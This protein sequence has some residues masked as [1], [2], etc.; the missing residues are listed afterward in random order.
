MQQTSA[1]SVYRVSLSWLFVTLTVLVLATNIRAQS[2][3]GQVLQSPPSNQQKSVQKPSPLEPY[4]P[5]EPS[6]GLTP[7]VQ[8]RGGIDPGRASHLSK[9]ETEY[10]AG[11]HAAAVP[12]LKEAVKESPGSYE[13]HYLLA[14]T[15]TETGKLEDAIAEFQKAI[16]LATKDGSKILAYYNMGNAHFDLAQY[17]KAAAAYEQA[18]KLDPTLSKPHYNLGLTHVGM[19]EISEA[20]E[21]FNAAIQLKPEYAEAHYN[22][23]VAYLQLGKRSE[24]VEQQ[25]LVSK[26]NPELATKLDHL[27]KK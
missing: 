19:N 5:R 24:A 26:L 17:A 22:L 10:R 4:A 25:K 15:L 27:I 7:I 16:E 3:G 1:R 18:L 14:L 9:G 12:E 6:I 20:A 11:R 2:A 23:G 21:Q 8:T 13:S